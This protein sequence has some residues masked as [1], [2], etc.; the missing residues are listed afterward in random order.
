VKIRAVIVDDETLA[1]RRI[2]LLAKEIGDLEIVGSC[3]SGPEALL[4]FASA[5]PDLLFLDVQMPQMDGFALL[6]ALPQERLPLV[7]FTTAWDQHAVAAFEAHALDYL[8][9]PFKPDRFRTAVARARELLAE[10]QAGCLGRNLLELLAKRGPAA[11]SA[12]A[13]PSP[14]YLKRL[15]L[16]RGDKVIVLEAGAIDAIESAGNYVVVHSGKEHHVL[17]ETLKALEE[18]L[19]PEKFLRI[20]RAAIVNLDRIEELHPLFKGEHAIVLKNGKRLIMTRGLREVE[21]ALRFG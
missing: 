7:I 10:R 15:T 4:A 21:K 14:V 19:D 13:R 2:E 9:K 6:A 5:Q 18:Q 11:A 17:R 16:R 12:D 8:L 1:R 20:S 3:A